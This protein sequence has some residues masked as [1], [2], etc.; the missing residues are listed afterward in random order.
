MAHTTMDHGGSTAAGTTPSWIQRHR[1]GQIVREAAAG[2][3]NPHYG[4]WYVRL[5]GQ[6]DEEALHQAWLDLQRRYPV[7]LCGFDGERNIWLTGEPAPPGP[8]ITCAGDQPRAAV[9][10]AVRAPF[11]L[12]A[13]PLCRLVTAREDS[14]TRLLA[15]VV[16]H[17]VCDA[18]SMDRLVVDL[19]ALY[20]RRLDPRNA[21]ELPPPGPT[22]VDFT[23]RENAHL[24]SAEGRRQVR[25]ALAAIEPVG[26]LPAL[27]LPGF[28]GRQDIDFTRQRQLVRKIDAPE[29]AQLTLLA[30]R[31]GLTLAGLLGA[32]MHRALGELS[33]AATVGTPV[34]TSNRRHRADFGVVGW[35]ATKFVLTSQP[36]GIIDHRDYLRHFRERF[37]AALRGPA[38]P[39]QR[40]IAEQHPQVFGDFTTIPYV[41]FNAVDRSSTGRIT[42]FA[43][44]A[45]QEVPLHIGG[46]DDSIKADWVISEQVDVLLSFKTDWYSSEDVEALWSATRRVHRQWLAGESSA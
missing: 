2:I 37:Y 24:D 12:A 32:S 23:R 8:L 20:T 21:P 10:N 19:D 41:T 45:A 4:V 17:L 44:L 9:E 16:D 25:A 40:L 36:L 31:S 7:L 39:W 13:G 30:R 46:R 11:D 22:Y 28:S 5:D 18:W 33:G 43:G 1:L 42:A 38:V 14:H 29:T 6:I 3:H 27:A 15:L 34:V 35:V 26:V